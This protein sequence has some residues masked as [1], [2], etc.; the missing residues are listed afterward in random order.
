MPQTLAISFE[1]MVKMHIFNG[2]NFLH[3]GR[4]STTPKAGPREPRG[5]EGACGKGE[6]TKGKDYHRGG[7]IIIRYASHLE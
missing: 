6:V 7:K 3:S 2:N 4:H 1:I 5:A